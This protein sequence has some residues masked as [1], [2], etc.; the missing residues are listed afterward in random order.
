[1]NL[2]PAFT[3][4]QEVGRSVGHLGAPHELEAKQVDLLNGQS[5]FEEQ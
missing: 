4:G 2:A 5:T 3:E 1:M